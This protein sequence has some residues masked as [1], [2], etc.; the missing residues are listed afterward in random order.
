MER[1]TRQPQPPPPIDSGAGGS[2][3]RMIR[4]TNEAPGGTMEGGEMNDAAVKDR[5]KDFVAE[6]IE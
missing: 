2:I 5:A 4:T 6:K 1:E 3:I